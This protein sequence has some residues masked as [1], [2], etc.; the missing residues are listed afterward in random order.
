MVP[1]SSVRFRFDLVCAKMWTNHQCLVVS[2]LEFVHIVNPQLWLAYVC[3]QYV[4]V[5][6]PQCD[7]VI[8]H[9]VTYLN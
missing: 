2:T 1:L 3:A 7:T 9:E 5:K 4:L 8:Q 6:V